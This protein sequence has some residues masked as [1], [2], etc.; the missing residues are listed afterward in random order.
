MNKRFNAIVIVVGQAGPSLA[1]RLAGAGRK[2][3]SIERSRGKIDGARGYNPQ[4]AQIL[5]AHVG[6]KAAVERRLSE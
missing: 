6:S 1:S 5:S 4:K 2:V 3:A